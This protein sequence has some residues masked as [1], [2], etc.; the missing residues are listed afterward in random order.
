MAERRRKQAERRSR[1]HELRQRRKAESRRM[2]ARSAGMRRDSSNRRMVKMME[3]ARA[4]QARELELR[5]MPGLQ[6]EE[7]EE[8]EEA[9]FGPAVTRG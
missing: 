3:E 1:A 9:Y 2:Q 4:R 5:R 8:E 6:E 7:D